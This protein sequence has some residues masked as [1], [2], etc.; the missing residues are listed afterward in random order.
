MIRRP[1]R[2]TL[3]R[4]S[5]ASDVYKRQTQSTWVLKEMVAKHG[6]KVVSSRDIKIF[7]KMFVNEAQVRTECLELL[8]EIYSF[9]GD[10]IWTSLSELNDKSKEMLKERF[11]QTEPKPIPK[12]VTKIHK[13]TPIKPI[14]ELSTPTK[15]VDPEEDSTNTQNETAAK[16][17]E[18]SKPE[19]S[20]T[21]KTERQ[22]PLKK[23]AG[24]MLIE[25]LT[26][27]QTMDDCMSALNGDE[28][29][30]RV[31]ALVFLNGRATPERS[32]ELAP[33]MSALVNSFADV[34]KETFRS[35]E[36]R[37][38]LIKYILEPINKLCR[39]KELAYSIQREPL[40]KLLTELLSNL[41]HTTAE[42]SKSLNSTIICLFDNCKPNFVFR[43][44]LEI[45]KNSKYDSQLSVLTV[46]CLIRLIGEFDSYLPLIGI[47]DLLIS[48]HE[49]LAGMS[50]NGLRNEVGARIAKMIVGKLVRAR[51]EDIWLQYKAVED[52]YG[53]K[54]TIMRRWIAGMLSKTNVISACPMYLSLIHISEPTR[55][56]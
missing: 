20:P 47:P 16:P 28:S 34:L 39:I 38:Q 19:E 21:V 45:Y 43:A 25:A 18:E 10:S 27:M 56:Y 5:A 31:D 50:D 23:M 46:K 3:D 9:K 40:L 41:P 32:S 33:Y 42:L 8:A 6:P 51:K 12:S 52:I 49:H 1:P 48:L 54:G 29:A 44:L 13:S 36:P 7:G 11:D 30:K 53:S 24:K 55:P 37:V 2:S 4:S 26:K 15:D 14:A 17:I 35:K 22:T